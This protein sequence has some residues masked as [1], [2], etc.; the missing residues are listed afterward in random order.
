MCSG[1]GIENVG[2]LDKIGE[3]GRHDKVRGGDVSDDGCGGLSIC[4]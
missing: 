4:G 3:I 1:R 2:C